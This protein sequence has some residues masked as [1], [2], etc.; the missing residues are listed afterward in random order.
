MAVKNFLHVI[1]HMKVVSNIEDKLI[2]KGNKSDNSMLYECMR[3]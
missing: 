3:C 2:L 1:Q